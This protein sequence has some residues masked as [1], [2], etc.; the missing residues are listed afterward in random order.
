MIF[1]PDSITFDWGMFDIYIASITHQKL[2]LLM[3]IAACKELPATEVVDPKFDWQTWRTTLKE[4]E[5]EWKRFA[6]SMGPEAAKYLYWGPHSVSCEGTSE[7]ISKSALQKIIDSYFGCTDFE[8]RIFKL[9]RSFPPGTFGYMYFQS[10]DMKNG[11]ATGCR[12]DAGCRGLNW[13]GN[14]TCFKDYGGRYQYYCGSSARHFYLPI[15]EKVWHDFTSPVLTLINKV[16]AKGLKKGQK[17]TTASGKICSS[18]A[19][20]RQERR[21][22]GVQG[23]HGCP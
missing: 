11:D 9:Y 14:G 2:V 7:I 5:G 12:F 4:F 19:I 22:R 1:F 20:C 23:V 18:G 16:P 13:T 21:R 10:G 8:G 15:A 6:F 17:A 3:L